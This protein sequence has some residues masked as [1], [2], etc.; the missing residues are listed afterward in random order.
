MIDWAERGRFPDWLLRWGI[1]RQIASHMRPDAGFDGER[2][3]RATASFIDERKRD[4]IALVPEL[5]NEQHYEVP[6]DLFE[7]MLGPRLKYS[8]C[9]WPVEVG[10]L[11][12]AEEAML[13]LTCERA[14]LADGQR[15]LDLGC[16]WGSFTLYAAECFPE[17]QF[18][19]VSNSA[20]QRGFIE[21]RA[22]QRGLTNIEVI[23]SDV[24]DLAFDTRFDRV[25]SVEMFEHVR[26]HERLLERI[27]GWLVPTGKLFV[28]LFC[29]DGIPL[30]YECDG[31]GQNDWMARHFFSGGMMP[32]DDLLLYYQRDVCVEDHWIVDGR[33]YSRTLEAWLQRLD[34][35][36]EEA[37][38]ILGAGE[39][40]ERAWR[41]F[42]RWRMFL[43]SCSELFAFD[44]GQRWH[45]GHYLFAPR[46][47]SITRSPE[48]TPLQ[49]AN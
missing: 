34:A 24:N 48:P 12:A 21:R 29:T 1:R 23:T 41:R 15:V 39:D 11:A 49:T 22:E 45:V 16:G 20:T 40:R 3:R 7:L 35:R 17:S 5:A 18:V 38:A 42:N 2:A 14:G 46:P 25:V 19:A 8:S 31:D 13:K 43:I 36:R 44:H 4:P 9:L 30:T 47:A 33:H 28:H 27:A 26:N 6:A 10:D 37:L 32:S